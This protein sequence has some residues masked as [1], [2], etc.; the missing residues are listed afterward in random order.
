MEA[1]ALLRGAVERERRVAGGAA[2]IGIEAV[3]DGSQISGKRQERADS[4]HAARIVRLGA[5]KRN[6]PATTYFPR[7]LPPEYL[8]RWRA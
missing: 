4:I 5:R 2:V 7:R 6:I 1:E 8:R 3:D